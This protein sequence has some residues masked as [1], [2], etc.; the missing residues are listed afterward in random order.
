[1]FLEV[2]DKDTRIALA[3]IK[4]YDYVTYTNDFI[5]VGSFE[6]RIPIIEETLQYLVE[7]NYILFDYGVVGIIK[8]VSTLLDE[9]DEV[10]ISG[11]LSKK[12]LTYRSFLLTTEYYNYISDIAFSMVD[13]LVVN[14]EDTRRVIDCVSL[15]QNT[16]YK[17]ITNNK[18]RVQNTGNTLQEVLSEMLSTEYFGFDL[19]PILS[20]S[21]DGP[22]ISTFEF[23][24]IKPTDRTIDNTDDNVPVVFSFELDNLL[25]LMFDSDSSTH[26]NVAIVSAEGQGT[27]RHQIEVGDLTSSGIYRKELYVDARDLQPDEEYSQIKLE[28][29]MKQRGLEKLLEVQRF[30]SFDGTINTNNSNYEFGVDFFLGDFVTVYSKELNKKI[31]VQIISITK[32]NSNGV[33]YFD[34]T[35]GYDSLSIKKIFN[36]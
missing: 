4:T 15:S 19:Y 29:R 13:D 7:D 18:I 27:L 36:N 22:N 30:E 32:S 10:K 23:R 33:E 28:E 11:F 24:I 6:I 17:P 3:L 21:N 25:S 34:I 16:L 1:M 35:F 31:N 9:I 14:P 12:L 5:G 8:K 20:S 26:C 2:F